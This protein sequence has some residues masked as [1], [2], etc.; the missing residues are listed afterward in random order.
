M[1][2]GAHTGW[3]LAV[4]LAVMLAVV[5]GVWWY[6]SGSYQAMQDKVALLETNVAVM[7]RHI[8]ESERILT[9]MKTLA[10]EV[11]NARMQSDADLAAACR[12][13]GDERYDRLMR[14]LE[15][16]LSRRHSD[17]AAGSSHGAMPGTAGVGG[18]ACTPA[19]GE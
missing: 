13:S 1:N 5:L 16:D 4:V 14:L 10:Q 9:A 17:S 15:A 12:S 2:T 19:S 11:K 8:N 7:Q 3:K 6:Y 18:S